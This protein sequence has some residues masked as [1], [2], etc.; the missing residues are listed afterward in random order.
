M[1]KIPPQL[2]GFTLLEILLVVVAI[3]I[4]AGIVIIAINPNKQLGDTRNAQRRIDVSIILNAVYQFSLDNN[5]TLPLTINNTATEICLDDETCPSL[6]ILSTDLVPNYIL[7]MPVDPSIIA[8]VGEG[9]GYT[10]FKNSTTGRVTV[11]APNAE[12]SATISITR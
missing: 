3:G 4:L 6:I 2:K 9:V 5:G 10:I 1:I 7:S 11:S 12:N 8:S